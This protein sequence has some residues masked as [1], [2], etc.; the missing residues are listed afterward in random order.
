MAA[1]G[2]RILGEVEES[3]LDE[4]RSAKKRT[5]VLVSLRD[6]MRRMSAC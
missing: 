2:S 4:V 6:V 1:V 5:D 3:S